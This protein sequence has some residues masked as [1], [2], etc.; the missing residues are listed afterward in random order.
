M[1]R[2]PE[3]TR[4]A[5]EWVAGTATAERFE[6][7]LSRSLAAFRRSQN[8]LEN[9]DTPS[10]FRDARMLYVASA[11]LY[12]ASA[13]VHREAI[14]AEGDM[15]TQLD[16]LARRTRELGERVFDRGRTELGFGPEETPDVVVHLPEEVPIWTAEGLAAG[17][18]LDD[19]P[20]PR[21]D[22]PPLRHGTRPEQPRSDWERDIDKA[23][24]PPFD[25]LRDADDASQWRDLARKF[26]EA[27]EYLRNRPDPPKG[28]EES[29]R[30][31]LSWLVAADAAR[32]AQAG[33]DDVSEQLVEVATMIA[34]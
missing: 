5:H 6:D 1:A 26:I 25:A 8:R 11:R 20:P 2:A 31:R 23:D 16:L 7:E 3:L 9:L 33:L 10:Q 4:V 29:A 21:A 30:L 34:P 22:S 27:A 12:V 32:A 24:A 13:L 15:R 18:P 28:R 17:P 19:P 14:G